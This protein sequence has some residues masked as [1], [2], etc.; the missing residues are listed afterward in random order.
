MWEKIIKYLILFLI[1]VLLFIVIH[2]VYKKCIDGFNVGSQ[3]VSICDLDCKFGL[4]TLS[5]VTVDDTQILNR[6]GSINTTYIS[7][8]IYEYQQS[9][10][11]R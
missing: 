1:G 2:K 11:N 9:V 6:D 5:T 3:V 4:N 10:N 7:Q 8:K